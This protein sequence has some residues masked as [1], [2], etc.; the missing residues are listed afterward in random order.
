MK[1]AIAQIRRLAPGFAPRIGIVLGSGLAGLVE[2]IADPIA[3]PYSKLAGFP[4]PTVS[5][6]S[7][8]LVLGRVAGKPVAVLQGREHYYERGRADAMK[9]PVR[10]LRALGCEILL[11]TNS[12][13]GLRPWAKPG[14]IAMVTDHIAWAGLS[15]LIGER[16]DAR[17]VD[18]TAVYDPEL[19]RRLK[20]AARQAGVRLVDGIYAWFPGPQFETPAEIRAARLLGADLAGMS[21]VAEAILA[22]HCGLRVAALSLVTNFGAGIGKGTLSHA[23]TLAA[24]RRGSSAV[25]RLVETFVAGL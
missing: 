17:F 10:A 21:T 9:A 20:A 6:H 15:P 19:R 25:A 5:G 14:A 24:A 1:T 22:R 18:Q 13:G 8:T 11:L 4:R 2:R 3:I 7:G 12:A 23:E 16:D